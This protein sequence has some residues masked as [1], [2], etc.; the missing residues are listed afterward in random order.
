MGHVIAGTVETLWQ[1]GSPL[2][3]TG[4]TERGLEVP[5]RFRVARPLALLPYPIDGGPVPHVL[6]LP[7]ERGGWRPPLVE[8]ASGDHNVNQLADVR[9]IA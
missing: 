2:Q 3:T 4:V 1:R 6:S 9:Q 8:G 7:S 5:D